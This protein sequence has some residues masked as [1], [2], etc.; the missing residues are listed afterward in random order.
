MRYSPFPNDIPTHMNALRKTSRA[1]IAGFF[2]LSMTALV[3]FL[4]AAVVSAGPVQAQEP[5]MRIEFLKYG[6]MATHVDQSR[7][8]EYIAVGLR[9]ESNGRG[10]VVVWSTSE[11]R[12]VWS[13]TFATARAPRVAFD[14]A[15][16]RLAV[17]TARGDITV[18]DVTDGMTSTPYDVGPPVNVL[19]FGPGGTL[20]AGMKLDGSGHMLERGEVRVWSTRLGTRTASMRTT[21][22]V[23]ALAFRPETSQLVFVGNDTQLTIWNYRFNTT[24]SIDTANFCS[25]RVVDVALPS[26]SPSIYFVT[27]SYLQ[28]EPNHFCVLNAES[29][30]L[31]SRYRRTNIRDIEPITPSRIAYSRGNYVYT[32]DLQTGAEGIA[33]ASDNNIQDLSYENGKLAVANSDV[34]VLNL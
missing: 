3:L 28:T 24:K 12:R 17:G 32:V 34:V 8:G 16:T 18:W 13:K 4:G 2:L 14:S 9:K 6:S 29:K 30:S 5:T 25:G 20:G 11:Q 23:R 26:D 10:Q 22:P 33:F 19:R 31:I 21:R 7:T 1:R 27:K 15:G